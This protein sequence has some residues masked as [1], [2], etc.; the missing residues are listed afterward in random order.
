MPTSC[1]QNRD[2]NT[3]GKY[4]PDLFR[5][6]FPGPAGDQGLQSIVEPKADHGKNEVIDAGDARYCQCLL[7]VMTQEDIIGDKIELWYENGQA[8]G[9][10]DL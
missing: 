3:L 6:V 10:S 7:V 2:I 8:D 9:R 4:L 1:N 5:S